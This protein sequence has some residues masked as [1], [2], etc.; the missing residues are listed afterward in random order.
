MKN[1][2]VA[3]V[4]DVTL[5]DTKSTSILNLILNVSLFYFYIIYYICFFFSLEERS[6]L[7]G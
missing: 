5:L 4:L 2:A 7:G 3:Q 6:L 1:R